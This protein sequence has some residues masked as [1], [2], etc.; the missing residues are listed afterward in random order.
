MTQTKRQTGLLGNSD[1]TYTNMR[2]G[3]TLTQEQAAKVINDAGLPPEALTSITPKNSPTY[4][5][6]TQTVN[7]VVNEPSNLP[8]SPQPASEQPPA[9]INSDNTQISNT[10]DPAMPA[11]DA[12]IDVVPEVQEPVY[13]A[14]DPEVQAYDEFAGLDQAVEAQQQFANATEYG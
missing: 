5:T 3:E 9:A 14:Q 6:A 11:Y 4:A 8:N 7:Q 12:S 13:P 10:T 1:G 2:T